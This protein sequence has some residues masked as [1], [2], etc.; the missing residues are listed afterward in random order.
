[1]LDVCAAEMAADELNYR[2]LLVRA[3][4]YSPVSVDIIGGNPL[5]DLLCVA[6]LNHIR[7]RIDELGDMVPEP[8]R[9]PCPLAK[10]EVGGTW[11]YATS[12]RRYPVEQVQMVRHKRK[13]FNESRFVTMGKLDQKSGRFRSYDLVAASSATPVIEWTVR[14]SRRWLSALL[15]LVA[16]IGKDRNAGLGSVR[17]WEVDD[18]D[19]DAL[20]VDGV[21]QRSLPCPDGDLSR[22]RGCGLAERSIR[23]PYCWSGSRVLCA[24]P[25][26][27]SP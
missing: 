19:R 7:I 9:I 27:D 25:S 26:V 13:R 24:V 16:S 6:V 12:W 17:A 5:D 23:P 11:V 18:T 10:V 21:P 22:Y 4:L 15:P 8:V 20:V 2:N 14:G 1:M 3:W